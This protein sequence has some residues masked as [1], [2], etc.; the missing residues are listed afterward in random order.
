MFGMSYVWND[1]V[2]ESPSIFKNKIKTIV[3][4]QFVQNWDSSVNNS[5]KCLIYKLYK[6]TF[7]FENYLINVPIYIA[8]LFCKFRCMSHRMPIKRDRPP[9]R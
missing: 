1:Q 6:Q 8:K 5:H 9:P 7:K 4:D 3:Q 2:V